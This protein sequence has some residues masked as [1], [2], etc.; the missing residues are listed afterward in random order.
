[1]GLHHIVATLSPWIHSYG[2]A[3]VF[4]ILLFESFGFP[5]P[6]ESLLIVAAISAGRGELSLPVLLLA[7]WG[8]AVAGDNIGYFIG[9][10]LGRHLLRRYGEKVGIKPESLHKVET[11]FAKYGAVTVM[12]A[13]FVN[14]LRQLNGLVA[15]AL[16]M[17]WLKFLIFNALGG[18]L[19]VG[20]WTAAGYYLGKHGGKLL[21]IAHEAGLYGAIGV[22]VLV[23]AGVGYFWYQ[24]R[25]ADAGKSK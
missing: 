13:R 21:R 6:G 17:H 8:G 2:S 16:E 20:T 3:A 12:F 25:H 9:R 4:L 7:A 5:L 18:A 10:W 22:G 14:I 23:A 1:M 24:A 19:W 11:A 15:G